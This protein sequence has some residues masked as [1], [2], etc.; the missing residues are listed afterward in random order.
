MVNVV[1]LTSQITFH[2]LYYDLKFNIEIQTFYP[3]LSVPAEVNLM[4][5]G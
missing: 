2:I 4:F 5:V 1:R 3:F